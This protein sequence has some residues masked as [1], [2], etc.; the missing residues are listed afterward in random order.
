MKRRL[1]G[2]GAALAL[3]AL[4]GVSLWEE[5][6]ARQRYTSTWWDVFDTVVTLTGYAPSQAEWDAQAGALH[7]DLLR[8]HQLFDIYNSYD[9]ITNLAD[10]N[11]RAGAGPVTVDATL[12]DLLQFGQ[13]MDAATEGACNIAA[14]AVLNLWHDARTAAE[15]LNPAAPTA[16]LL[17][18]ED[19]LQTAAQHCAMRDLILDETALTVAFAD[20]ALRLDVGSIGK[21]YAVELAAKA[22]EARGLKSALLNAGGNIRAIGTKPDGSRWTAGVENPWLDAEGNAALADYVAEV[23]LAPGESLVIS[24]DY[25]RYFTVDGVRYH[26]LIDLTTLQPARYCSS[27]AVRCSGGSGLADA[28]STGLFCMPED[29][30]LALVNT[31]DNTEAL[32]M[33]PDGTTNATAHFTE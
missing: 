31:L 1:I 19:A 13:R 30:G 26:H 32:W 6:H 4:V 2:L 9:S 33:N 21:G 25:Q 23:A 16:D 22:A 29:K 10:V 5:T 28:L 20:P 8:C 27:V 12:F 3:V 18:G 14:G 15:A 24:G 11:A 17:P 7:D